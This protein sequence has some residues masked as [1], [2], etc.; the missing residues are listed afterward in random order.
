MIIT[1]ASFKGGVGK[2]TTAAHLA[3]YLHATDGPALLVDGDPNK[4]AGDWAKRGGDAFPCPT[5]DLYSAPKLM[6]KAKHTVIDTAARPS[7]DELE[8]L[9]NGCDLLVLPTTAKALDIGALMKTVA[10]LKSFGG[11]NY[12]VLL[13]MIQS[14]RT[15]GE[16][17]RELIAGQGLHVIKRPIRFYAAHEKAS[18][19]GCLVGAVKGDRNA[20]IA[21]SDYR[22]ACEEIVKL[23]TEGANNA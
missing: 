17:A 13:T 18:L 11:A 4:S 23:A 10:T 3:N 19:K 16:Q 2:T 14:G 22:Q 7:T 5:A 15:V 9:I 12:A 21:A 8:S 1:I 20:K 6:G